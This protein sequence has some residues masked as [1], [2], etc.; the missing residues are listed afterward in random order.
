MA[1]IDQT[2]ARLNKWYHIPAGRELTDNEQ[3]R[4]VKLLMAWIERQL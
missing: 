2:F 4:I 1:T 3:E